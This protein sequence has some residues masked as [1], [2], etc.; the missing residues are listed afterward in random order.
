MLSERVAPA[1][2]ARAWPV[3]C[4]TMLGRWPLRVHAT[5]LVGWVPSRAVP[6]RCKVTL[7]KRRRSLV[8]TTSNTK[9]SS[10]E[11]VDVACQRRIGDL[12]TDIVE[13]GRNS[14]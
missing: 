6:A 5:H 2:I 14:T 11:C 13:Q 3:L 9:P 10:R 4:E 12:L 8:L 7:P 1:H